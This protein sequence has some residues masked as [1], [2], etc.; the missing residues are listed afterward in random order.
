MKP[1][2]DCPFCGKPRAIWIR[3]EKVESAE[4][5]EGKKRFFLQYEFIV[6]CQYGCFKTSFTRQSTIYKPVDAY[7]EAVDELHKEHNL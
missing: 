2:Y 1:P 6:W 7:C 3:C 4:E 5:V